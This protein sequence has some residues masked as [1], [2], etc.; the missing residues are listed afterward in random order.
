MVNELVNNKKP[1]LRKIINR[2]G[3]LSVNL[4]KVL[5]SKFNITARDHVIIDIEYRDDQNKITFQKLP[6]EVIAN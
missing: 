5:C 1:F 6:M 3:T 4:P 2:K